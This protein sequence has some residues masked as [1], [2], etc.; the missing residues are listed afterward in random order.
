MSHPSHASKWTSSRWS[1]SITNGLSQW[2]H[3]VSKTSPDCTKAELQR[4]RQTR[5]KSISIVNAPQGHIIPVKRIKISEEAGALHNCYFRW[6]LKV[7]ASHHKWMAFP[8]VCT[9]LLLMF[10]SSFSYSLTCFHVSCTV[11]EVG[12]FIIND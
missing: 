8:Q 2:H 5:W 6:R 10:F 9:F 1:A 7:T 11:H 3:H 12:F 4:Q